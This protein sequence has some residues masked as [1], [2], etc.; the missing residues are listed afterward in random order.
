MS[1]PILEDNLNKI[2]LKPRFKEELLEDKSAILKKFEDYFK[3]DDSKFRTKTADSHIVIDV[4]DEEDHFWSPQLQIEIITEDDK[5]ILKGLFG[6]KPQVWTM[7]M[8]FHFAVAF[9]FI[10]FLIMAYTKY[11]LKQDYQFSMYMCIAM[12]ILWILFYVFGQLGKKKG[13]SQMIALDA[14]VKD[15][16]GSSIQ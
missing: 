11:S 10:V 4:P 8:F 15:I 5:T 16:L 13:Y 12:P 14:Y 1:E 2:L 9:A 3:Q 6:P 7:F